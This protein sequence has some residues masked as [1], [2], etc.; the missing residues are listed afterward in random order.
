MLV[1][2]RTAHDRVMAVQYL[3]ADL[4]YLPR[5]NFIGNLGLATGNAIRAFQRANGLP[6][7]GAFTDELVS[8]VYR[9]A[10]KTEPPQGHLFVRQGFNRVFDLPISFRDPAVSLG[11]HVFTVVK[12]GDEGKPEWMAVSLEGG[13]AA[14]ALDRIDIPD[15]VRRSIRQGLT[16][17]STLIVADRSEYSAI[18]PEGDDFLVS[19]AEQDKAEDAKVE[20]ANAGPDEV[21]PVKAKLVEAADRESGARRQ[22]QGPMRASGA[23]PGGATSAGLRPAACPICLDGRTPTDFGL[24]HARLAASPQTKGAARP[25]SRGSGP[26]QRAAQ[27]VK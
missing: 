14:A 8:Q 4:G 1:T 12:R 18:L 16:P 19:T 3:L 7:T 5:Q 27:P 13:D 20:Q 9:A 2:R 26:A 11:T 24:T 17:G 15:A 10:D 6:V 21:A 23:R 25:P 22:S